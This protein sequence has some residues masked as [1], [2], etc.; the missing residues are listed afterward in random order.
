MKKI[1][2]GV[3]MSLDGYI[4]A[5]PGDNYDWIVKDPEINFAEI[6]AQ[7]DTLLMGRLTYEVAM[8]MGR[9]AFGDMKVIVVSR[10]LRPVDHPG[11]TVISELTRDWLRNLRSQQG[12]DIWLFGGCQL[13]RAVLE[14]GEL[15]AIDV[16]VIPVIL[17]GGI[18]LIGGPVPQ[19]KLKLTSHKIYKSGIASLKYAV[20]RG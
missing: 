6:F 8:T 14:L 20:L 2:Y 17:G 10:T 4:A 12:K 13:A 19:T 5:G 11:A 7:Y 18:S 9:E 15:D 1:R 3:A 16:S